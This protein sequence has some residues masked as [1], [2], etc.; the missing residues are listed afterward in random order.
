MQIGKEEFKKIVQS[1][2]ALD[3]EMAA[4]PCPAD[5]LPETWDEL[6]VAPYRR[7]IPLLN[8]ILSSIL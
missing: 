5:V 2:L 3:K 7:E 6:M 8:S 4:R 1:E